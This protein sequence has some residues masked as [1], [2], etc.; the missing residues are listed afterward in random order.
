MSGS[1]SDYSVS[2]QEMQAEAA[3][4]P[5]WIR[6]TWRPM[7]SSLP[8]TEREQALLKTARRRDQFAC[9]LTESVTEEQVWRDYYLEQFFKS[10]PPE[11]TVFL[12]RSIQHATDLDVWRVGWTYATISGHESWFQLGEGKTLT[13]AIR[14]TCGKR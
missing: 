3:P 6:H 5:A 14:A 8:V 12:R 7:K 1:A 2:G 9:P 4:P 13:E 10:G 11:T